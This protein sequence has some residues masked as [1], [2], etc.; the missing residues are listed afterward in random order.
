MKSRVVTELESLGMPVDYFPFA[1]SGDNGMRQFIST[2]ST[3]SRL[4]NLQSDSPVGGDHFETVEAVSLE[5]LISVASIGAPSLIKL[6]IEGAEVESC[7]ASIDALEQSQTLVA[8]SAYHSENDLLDLFQI[9]G[10]RSRRLS[11]RQYGRDGT[12]LVLLAG[13]Q[14]EKDQ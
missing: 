10:A 5:Q 3:S 6:D 7:R 11:L 13:F 2:G 9:L 12:D 4:S 1:V 14:G 8:T